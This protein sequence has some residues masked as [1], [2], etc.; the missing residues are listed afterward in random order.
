M[1]FGVGGGKA[2]QSALALLISQAMS[3]P[4]EGD[5]CVF[6]PSVL[7]LLGHSLSISYRASAF[8][9]PNVRC[10][11]LRRDPPQLLPYCQVLHRQ[12]GGSSHGARF[13]QIRTDRPG[14]PRKPP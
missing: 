6:R 13:R 5:R 7:A 11:R 4:P 12:F 8:S 9:V 10:T 1:M 3:A 14:D 2:L